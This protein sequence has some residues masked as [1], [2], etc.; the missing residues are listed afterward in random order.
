M[1]F[2]DLIFARDNPKGLLSVAITNIGAPLAPDVVDDA[3]LL[4]ARWIIKDARVTAIIVNDVFVS[5]GV[6][7]P[8]RKD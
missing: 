5:L 3:N 1:I 8:V 6:R 2:R 7:W 4:I